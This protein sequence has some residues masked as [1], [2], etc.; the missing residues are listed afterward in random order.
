V[1]GGGGTGGAAGGTGGKS[2]VAG[3]GN[4]VERTSP[5][6]QADSAS[7]KMTELPIAILRATRVSCIKTPLSVIKFAFKHGSL[8]LILTSPL[9]KAAFLARQLDAF[10]FRTYRQLDF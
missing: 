9:S 2:A 7:A 3:G 1:G 8:L 5:P 6:P 10:E 4:G